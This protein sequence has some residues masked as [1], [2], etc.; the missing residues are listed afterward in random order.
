MLTDH[1]V[2]GVSAE[3]YDRQIKRGKVFVS[4]D[5][6]ETQTSREK[7]LEILSSKGG[8]SSAAS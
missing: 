3:F 8:E 2:D 6:R 4:V 5:T 7:C 1:D